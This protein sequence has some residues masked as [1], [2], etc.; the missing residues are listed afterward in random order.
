MSNMCKI[1]I[2]GFSTV[3]SKTPQSVR[4]S[5]SNFVEILLNIHF[6][7]P[8]NFKRL[9]HLIFEIFPVLKKSKLTSFFLFLSNNFGIIT[10]RPF[11]LSM[12]VPIITFND[13]AKFHIVIS[14]NFRENLKFVQNPNSGIFQILACNSTIIQSKMF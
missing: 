5:C 9:F 8:L 2:Q 6:N 4:A 13:C 12:D 11:L 7:V 1:K 10:C 14:F 3:W